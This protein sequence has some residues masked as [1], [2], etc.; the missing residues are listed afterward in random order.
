MAFEFGPHRRSLSWIPRLQLC[1]AFRSDGKGHY[2][3][4]LAEGEEKWIKK[5][6]LGLA[7]WGF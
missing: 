2:T 1:S 3:E 4:G 6:A 7:M 5:K